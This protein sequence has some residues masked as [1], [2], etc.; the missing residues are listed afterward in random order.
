MEPIRLSG[1]QM[2]DNE[3]TRQIA[4]EGW[5]PQHDDE[6]DD[7]QLVEAARAYTWAALC[8]VKFGANGQDFN[9][10][11]NDWPKELDKKW[12]KPSDSPVR[13]LVKAGALIVAEID[14]LQRKR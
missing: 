2:I 3:R 11:P 13:N 6:H 12:W 9:L 8:E 1:S 4:S 14:R 10:L 7:A 5:S